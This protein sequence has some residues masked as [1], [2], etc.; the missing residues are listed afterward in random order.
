[1]KYE[2]FKDLT[3]DVA[4]KAYGKDM[5]ELFK[6]SALAL[7]DVICELDKVKPDKMII[8]EVKGDGYKDLL[9]NWL[10]EL[11]AAVD[12]K[13]M[14]FSKFKVIGINDRKMVAECYG[15]EIKPENGK[16]LVK[17]VTNYLF[18][19]KEEKGKKIAV[20]SLDI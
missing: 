20:V 14:F 12:T 9:F 3:S 19:L 11:I 7:F 1:M 5:R 4:F 17:A 13:E 16:T 18:D 6:N 8:V 10:Q 2:Y 15:D